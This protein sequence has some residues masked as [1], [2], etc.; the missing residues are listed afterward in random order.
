MIEDEPLIAQH[1]AQLAR[2]AGAGLVT[3]A[4]SY[5]E[6]LTAA[7]ESLPDI[8]LCDFDLSE[9]KTGIDVVRALSA[10]YDTLAVFVTAYPHEVL[11]GSD[12]EPSFIISKPF[13]DAVV[14]AA[15]YYAATSRRP[16]VLAA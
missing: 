9:E 14:K 1:L 6:A 7:A 12:H 4:R 2:K 13:R 3:V 8:A 10:E 11:T 15:L 5:D 16:D